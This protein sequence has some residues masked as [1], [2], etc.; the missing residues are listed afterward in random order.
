MQGCRALRDSRWC[1]RE[2][3]E[4]ISSL[5]YHGKVSDEFPLR[6]REVH[7]LVDQEHSPLYLHYGDESR[8]AKLYAM[9]LASC[10]KV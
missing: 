6:L 9:E 1:A 10:G 3:K 2:R 4:E 5:L 8:I 7:A